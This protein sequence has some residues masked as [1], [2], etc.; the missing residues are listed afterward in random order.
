MDT[1]RSRFHQFSVDMDEVIRRCKKLNNPHILFNDGMVLFFMHSTNYTCNLF[2]IEV[3]L[4]EEDEI[5]N[6]L[7]QDAADK[8]E[9]DAIFVLGML[10]M[11]EG[12]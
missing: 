8:G 9:L 6:K 2:S 10:L 1:Y 5:G 4:L 11:A 7:L 12:S 3:F